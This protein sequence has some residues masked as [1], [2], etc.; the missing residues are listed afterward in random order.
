[1]KKIEDILKQM[2]PIYIHH[3]IY[4][5]TDWH[6]TLHTHYFSEILYVLNG[7]GGFLADGQITP[8]E[9]GSLIVVNPYV[10]HTEVSS[11]NTPLEYF[12]IG[13]NKVQFTNEDQQKNFYAIKHTQ[14]VFKN[15]IPLILEEAKNGNSHDLCKLPLC[16]LFLIDLM[17]LEDFSLENVDN[18]RLNKDGAFIKDYIDHHFKEQ[19]SLESISNSLHLDK[20]YI[21]HIF[22]QTYSDTPMNYLLKVRLMKAKELLINTDYSVAEIAEIVGFSSQSYF[23]QAF[24][25]AYSLAPG[26][27]RKQEKIIANF[28]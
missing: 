15:L 14:E 26:K 7:Q 19:I 18:K 13:I 11:E 6:S 20:Y 1:M 17:K 10:S 3:S 23:N 22:K 25:K 9:K 5:K 21:I 16:Q 28:I 2:E 4:E 12:V 24:K 27:Y 8:I